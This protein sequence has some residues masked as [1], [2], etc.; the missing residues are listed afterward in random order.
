MDFHE[1]DLSYQ[2]KMDEKD[3]VIKE[4]KFEGKVLREGIKAYKKLNLCYRLGGQPPEW[5]FKKI[6]KLDKFVKDL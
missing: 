6:E 3:K 4:L 5:V 1:P 2:F